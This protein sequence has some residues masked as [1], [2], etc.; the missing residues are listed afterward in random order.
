MK[1]EKIRLER[2]KKADEEL[3]RPANQV[4]KLRLQANMIERYTD[5]TYSALECL[6]EIS[7]MLPD[8]VD[9]MSFN[10]RKGVSMDIDGE[11]DSPQ[12]VS[13]FNGALN[14]S[15][16]FSEVKPGTKTL[17]KTGRQRFSFDIK[18]P[19]EQL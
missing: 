18:F 9:L 1:V 15:K 7:G 12:L 6:R 17:T 3:A 8:G 10:Y 2:L 14:G 16:L 19:E 5:R 13:S 4:R 11:A